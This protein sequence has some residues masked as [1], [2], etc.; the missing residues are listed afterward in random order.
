MKFKKIA[1]LGLVIA[2]CCFSGCSNRTIE[3]T[4]NI[5]ERIGD[6]VIVK[7]TYYS[8]L[9]LNNITEYLV[10]NKDTKIMYTYT[11]SVYGISICPYYEVNDEGTPVI[12]IYNEGI[13]KLKD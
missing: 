7:E 6:Y 5:G 11:R 4:D 1:A 2:C 13:E 8:D 3:K 10:Y 12:K 9:H